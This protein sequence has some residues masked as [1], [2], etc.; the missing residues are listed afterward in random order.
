MA[1][2]VDGVAAGDAVAGVT[3]T[4]FTDARATADMVGMVTLDMVTLDAAMR[5]ASVEV[6]HSTARL[7]VASTEVEGSMAAA[8]MVAVD[9][10]NWGRSSK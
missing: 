5:G 8:V 10:G 4:A 3:G 2:V 9:I 7:E 1:G 6:A